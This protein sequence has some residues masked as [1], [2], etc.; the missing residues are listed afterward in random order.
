M[1]TGTTERRKWGISSMANVSNQVSPQQWGGI[2]AI[3]STPFDDQG[4]LDHDSLRNLLDFTVACGAHGILYPAMVSE[5]FTLS[6]AER[7]RLSPL[8]VS[9][10]AGRC[11]VVIGVSGVCTQA[12]VDLAQ[13]AEAAGADAVMA[14]PPYIQRYSDD[15]VLRHFEAISRVVSVPI[16]IQNAGEWQPVS[17][18]LVLRIVHEIEHVH[19]V[20]EEVPPAHHNISALAALQDP[21]IWGLFGGHGGL[22]LLAELRRGATGNMP[23]SQFTDILVTIY[24]LYVG[25]AEAEAEALH[26]R[27]MPLIQHAGPQ[28]EILVKRGIIRSAKTRAAQRP[29]DD[30]DRRERDRTWPELAAAFTYRN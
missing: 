27:L 19:F 25:G 20:K 2:F 21:E 18:A 23:G 12:A 6:E 11:P 10:V 14:M 17:R 15:D 22:H 9:Q 26:R 16:F 29:F 4:E 8:V 28:K 30:Q 5:F 24:N 1:Q 3:P 7:I 13:A